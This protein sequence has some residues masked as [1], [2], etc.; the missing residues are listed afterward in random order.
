MRILSRF[1]DVPFDDPNIALH[2]LIAFATDNQQRMI[3]NNSGGEFSGRITALTGALT[4]IN[5]CFTDDQ[6]Q[7]GIRK[8]RKQAKDEL[9]AAIPASVAKLMGAVTAEYGPDSPEVTECCPQGRTIFSTS[10]DDQVSQH[11]EVLINGITAHQA[12]LGEPLVLKATA[13][14]TAWDTVYAASEAASGG[15]TATE[16]EKQAARENLQ[17][18]LYLNLVKLMEVFPRQPEKLSLYMTQ[19]LLEVP[20]SGDGDDE[21]E[22][23]PVPTPTP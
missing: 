21:P 3:A 11:L 2:R 22:T 23:P 14:K 8:A 1:L 9:R 5:N 12:T 20:G 6:T 17:L 13:L 10:A 16:E 19:S 7:L 4:I 18:M 15:K